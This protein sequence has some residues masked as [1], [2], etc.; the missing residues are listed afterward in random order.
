[1]NTKLSQKAKNSVEKDFLKLMNNAVF[2]KTTMENVRKYRDIRL[3]ATDDIYKDIA[4]GVEKD[5]TLPI[6]KQADQ[7]LQQKMK[8]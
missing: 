4:E 7:Y 8:K 6:L 2:E 3:V 1:M 5:L